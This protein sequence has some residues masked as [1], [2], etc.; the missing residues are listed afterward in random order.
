MNA[1]SSASSELKRAGG[2]ASASAIC[3]FKLAE[4]H[5]NELKGI[6]HETLVEAR[7]E[8][9]ETRARRVRRRGCEAQRILEWGSWQA[10]PPD[11]VVEAWRCVP[12][13]ESLHQKLGVDREPSAVR[14][15]IAVEDIG[16]LDQDHAERELRFTF[17]SRIMGGADARGR[18]VIGR[19]RVVYLVDV[20]RFVGACA[21]ANS[22]EE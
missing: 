12:L 5:A 1:A 7:L 17:W 19:D 6:E 4:T 20:D 3:A 13:G 11:G 21:R 14:R 15:Q 8:E 10:I 16:D 18:F 9:C 2:S 22:E